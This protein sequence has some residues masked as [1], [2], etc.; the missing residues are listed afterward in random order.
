M[1]QDIHIHEESAPMLFTRNVRFHSLEEAKEEIT[2][3]KTSAKVMVS[4]GWSL[5]EILNHCSQS[6]EFSLQGFPEYKSVFFQKTIGKLAFLVFKTRGYMNHNL[7]D[8]IP[9]APSI[10]NPKEYNAV[11]NRVE[12]AIDLFLKFENELKPHFAYGS[13]NKKGYN[14]AHAMHIAN[15]FSAIEF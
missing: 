3:L 5:P 7:A 6:I 9:S 10:I 13:I 11:F 8:P 4:P 14:M 1:Y 2:R 15:H 12:T